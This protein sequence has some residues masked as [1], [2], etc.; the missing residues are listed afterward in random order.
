MGN[1]NY[2]FEALLWNISIYDFLW[3]FVI[4]SF[5]GWCAEVISH[6]VT[7]NK[8][9]NR[10]FLN[11]SYCPIYGFGMVL[12]IIFLTPIEGNILLLFIGSILLTTSLELITGFILEKLFQTRWWDYSNQKLNIGGY[13]CL[14]YSILWGFACVLVM[15]IIQPLIINFINIIPQLIG[16]IIILI[17]ILGMIADFITV[18][19]GVTSMNKK[20]KMAKRISNIIHDNSDKIGEKISDDIL[21]LQDKVDELSKKK[22]IIQRRLEKSYPSLAKLSNIPD[23]DEIESLIK[24]IHEIRINSR[25]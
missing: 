13:V 15:K 12:V 7:L 22:G 8:F 19:I 11:G 5:L 1:D 23:K 17:I 9:V 24:H 18:I 3:I 14:K 4:Y 16:Q 10:G 6:T 2:M 21:N 25:K 20:M